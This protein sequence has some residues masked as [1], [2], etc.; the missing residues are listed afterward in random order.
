[1]TSGDE[2]KSASGRCTTGGLLSVSRYPLNGQGRYI[3]KV[4]FYPV[5]TEYVTH[6]WCIIDVATGPRSPAGNG[7]RTPPDRREKE[8]QS[9]PAR[10]E[11]PLFLPTKTREVKQTPYA[12]RPTTTAAS[13]VQK[14][15]LKGTTR[16]GTSVKPATGTTSSRYGTTTSSKAVTAKSR[17]GAGAATTIKPRKTPEITRSNTTRVPATARCPPP[18]YARSNSSVTPGSG[19]KKGHAA[20]ATE[21]GGKSP[22]R[23]SVSPVRVHKNPFGAML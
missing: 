13:T 9:S 18:S 14:S 16:S 2:W 8:R 19:G 10:M 3:R 22:D 7:V 20:A 5:V 6:F 21:S 11:T 17:I 23:A 15:T 12:A 4:K 1:M